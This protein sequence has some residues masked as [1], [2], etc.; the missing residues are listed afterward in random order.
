[1]VAAAERGSSWSAGASSQDYPG[2]DRHLDH[3]QAANF[4]SLLGGGTIWAGTP[5]DIRQ[6]VSY[7]VEA[8]GRF[9]IA[10]LQVNI[11]L[12]S[13]SDAAESMRIFSQEVMSFFES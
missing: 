12:V 9:D 6:Q 3:F 13:A 2:C 11:H 10:S 1:M 4:D 8:V 7:Y 5:E